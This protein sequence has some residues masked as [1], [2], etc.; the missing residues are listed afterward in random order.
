MAHHFLGLA[1]MPSF[2]KDPAPLHRQPLRVNPLIEHKL[3]RVKTC[4]RDNAGFTEIEDKSPLIPRE[5]TV[6]DF[7]DLL[8]DEIIDELL[9]N[10]MFLGKDGADTLVQTDGALQLGSILDDIN[11]DNAPPHQEIPE[12]F[13]K[14]SGE[15]PVNLAVMENDPP[16][17]ILAVQNEFPRFP[18]QTDNLQN[19]AETEIFKISNKA[20]KGPKV[21]A[22]REIKLIG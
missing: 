18:A 1:A 13:R 12:I 5:K 3:Q 2:V 10:A 4:G 7:F 16:L 9:G 22:A 19:I 21:V 11:S 17:A 15:S 14:N 6:N 20:H 8:L